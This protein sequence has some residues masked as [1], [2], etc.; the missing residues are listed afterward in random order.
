ML[1]SQTFDEREGVLQSALFDNSR[2]VGREH[3]PTILESHKTHMI[4]YITP[5]KP[6]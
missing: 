6:V 5:Q 1:L 4:F 3:S 2:V